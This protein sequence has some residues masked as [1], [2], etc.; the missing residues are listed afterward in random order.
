MKYEAWDGIGRAVVAAESQERAESLL[1]VH[2]LERTPRR[3]GVNQKVT[4][5][6]QQDTGVKADKK[7]IIAKF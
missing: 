3:P 7:G 1:E 5:Y 2:L 6:K 4:I